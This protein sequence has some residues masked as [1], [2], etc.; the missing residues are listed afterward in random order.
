ML[1]WFSHC[2]TTAVAPCK[3]RLFVESFLL[4]ASKFVKL[5]T[6]PVV[7]DLD[8]GQQFAWRRI[9]ILSRQVTFRWQ[10]LHMPLRPQWLALRARQS[11]LC[12][13]LGRSMLLGYGGGE[14]R[15]G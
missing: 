6:L 8:L 5:A 11:R 1:Q 13:L 9:L 3:L 15:N 14:A 2:A 10:S 12:L 7:R 4:L